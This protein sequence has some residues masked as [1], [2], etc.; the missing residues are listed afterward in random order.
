MQVRIFTVFYGYRRPIGGKASAGM[1]GYED[2]D[3]PQEAQKELDEFLSTKPSIVHIFQSTGGQRDCAV[4]TITIF[5][6]P[7]QA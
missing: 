4:T 6:Q 5:Y 2:I 1:H 7:S 3:G